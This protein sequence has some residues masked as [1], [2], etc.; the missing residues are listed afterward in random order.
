[1]LY[2]ALKAISV[3]HIRAGYHYADLRLFGPEGETQQRSMY[4]YVMK[5]V[6]RRRLRV[7]TKE[8]VLADTASKNK[9]YRQDE[10]SLFGTRMCET[11]IQGPRDVRR[12]RKRVKYTGDG[13]SLHI[14]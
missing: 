13:I 6:M 7:R 2:M 12:G 14:R 3:P 9:V 4:P 5:L 1:M 10:P 8:A 11:T